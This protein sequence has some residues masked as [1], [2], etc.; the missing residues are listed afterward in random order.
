MELKVNRTS[1]RAARRFGLRVVTALSAAFL[2]VPSSVRAEDELSA[3]VFA[4]H[5]L[6][7]RAAGVAGEVRAAAV[8]AEMPGVPLTGAEASLAILWAPFFENAIVK[9]GRV[10][11]AAPVALYYNPLLDIAVF[12]LWE[13]REGQYRV[14][15]I[16]ALPGENLADSEATVADSAAMDG[17]RE[18]A[19]RCTLKNH[20]CPPRRLP[21]RPSCKRTGRRS[22]PPYVRRCRG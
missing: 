6:D 15:S 19:G 2:L 7:L 10:Q 14:A 12:T 8:L 9:L 16:R 18:W 11:S 17:R 20:C 5:A 4:A 3:R 13:R 21:P 22:R 1:A